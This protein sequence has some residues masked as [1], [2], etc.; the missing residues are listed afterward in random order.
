MLAASRRSVLA[1]ALAAA[2]TPALS[3]SRP[4]LS[5]SRKAPSLSGPHLDLMTPEG[6][7]RAYALMQG[8]L[9]PE[10]TSYSWYTGRVSGHRPGEAGR[11]LMRI[12]GMGAV[13]LLPLA[14]EPG[15]MML[16]KEL[17]FFTDLQTGAV[18]DRWQNPYIDE[19]V[20]VVHL[21]NP[22]I[23]SAIKPHVREQGLYE[24]V[25]APD[26]VKPFLLP[27]Q[28][29]GDRAMT[30]I[31][32]H[33]RAKNPLDPAKWPR[34]SSG[35]EVSISDSNSFNVAIADLQNPAL[36]KVESFGHWSH[37]RPWQPWML[38]GQAEGHIQYTCFTGSS[39]SLD[40][41]PAQIVALARTRFPDFLDAPRE[42]TRAESSL[43]R[44]MR[45]RTPA[46][47]KG[48]PK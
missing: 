9:D 7:A 30:E 11:D 36:T 39:A 2:S 48:Q 38:M 3:A 32:A 15:W 18:I 28:Q 6:N 13:R 14:G 31:H 24:T 40:R 29:V 1:A 10:V 16:R 37:S 27:W 25:G 8:S 44:Y 41:M 35:A 4:A 22:A 21:A 17:G 19:E 20:E 12:I 5:A 33:I 43:A 26:Q 45:T 23:N 47:A 46:P 34:E 42:V